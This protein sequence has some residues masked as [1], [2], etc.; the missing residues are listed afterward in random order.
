M[1]TLIGLGLWDEFDISL[2]TMLRIKKA[3]RVYIELYTSKWYGNLKRLEKIIG[4][5]VEILDRKD[6]EEKSDKILEEAKDKDVVIFV[7]GDPLIATTHV[8]LLSNAKKMG[9]D[10]EVIHNAS[11]YSAI[12]ETGL[13]VY[14][15]GATVTI[16]FLEKTNEFLPF[17]IYEKIKENKRNDLHTLILLDVISEE[18]KYMTPNQGMK[19]LLKT[20]E[21]MR[22]KIFTE[23]T[24]V[25][26]FTR[27]GSKGPMIVYGKVKDM[28]NEDFG[29]PPFVIIAP[30][31]LH[32]T[33][34]E[35]LE[36][37]RVG[38]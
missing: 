30:S 36:Y 26:V 10:V 9:I 29:S 11:I 33:E 25:V 1:L 17:S 37:H 3:D 2:K 18:K 13:H 6:L 27:A 14:K 12:G 5:E 32:F 35:Y 4:K 28:I 8:S 23:D 22:K 21:A 38:K 34:K 16:P 20:E 24:E 15:F 7:P 31:R 19:I